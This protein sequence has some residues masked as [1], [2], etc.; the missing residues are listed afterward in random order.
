MRFVARALLVIIAVPIFILTVLSINIRFQFL[1]SRFW[2]N[3][4]EKGNIY[5]QI[6]ENVENR[7]ISKVVAEGGGK[8]DVALLSNLISPTSLKDFSEKN[9]RN[10]LLYANG[11]SSQIMVFTPVPLGKIPE[12][13]GKN[14]LENFSEEIP[15]TD[16][17]KGFDISGIGESDIQAISDFGTW[18]WI[19]T[20]G[21]FS[22]LVLALVLAYLTTNS[23]KHLITPGMAL[24]LPGIFMLTAYLVGSFAGRVLTDDF[25]ESTNVGT[26][27][28]AIIIPPVIQNVVQIWIWFGTFAVILGIL[29]F[30]LK[31]P[32]YNDA[33]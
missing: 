2:I 5:S 22:L 23:G 3:T 29:L 32:V 10:I 13:F 12:G 7:L 15:L 17:L 28:A 33:K 19:L 24:I 11:K 4:F 30:F 31:K 8:S 25:R 6:S 21:S 27:L 26:S 18:A 14:N 20:A 16:F 1:S 9:I